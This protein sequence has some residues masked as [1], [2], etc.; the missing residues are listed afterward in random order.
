MYGILFGNMIVVLQLLHGVSIIHYGIISRLNLTCIL[1][2]EHYRTVKCYIYR[3]FHFSEN[4]VG[5]HENQI[6]EFLGGFTIGL[7]YF[8]IYS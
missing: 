6:G 8:S 7:K 3:I 2:I 1:T 4:F 5:L